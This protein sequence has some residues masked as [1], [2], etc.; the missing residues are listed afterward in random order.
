MPF[1][2]RQRQN[3]SVKSG[4]ANAQRRASIAGA[5]GLIIAAV[6]AVEGGYV[7][8]PADPGGAT[9]HGVTEEVA[10]QNG[11]TGDMRDFPRE[12]SVEGEVCAESIYRRDYI[13]RPGYLP[14]VE[15]DPVV[16]EEVIDTAVNM[17]P[18]RPSRW[19]QQSVNA[20]C[21]TRLAVDGRIGPM[22]LLAWRECRGRI[23]PPA[24][25]DML[26]RMDALQEAE[27][28]RLVRVN[29]RLARFRRGWQNHRIGNVA[30]ERCA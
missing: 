5:V 18:R 3:T 4:Q 17:G 9:N 22:T 12:C 26:D 30:R 19:F 11:Y 2:P 8:D 27:Y 6:F 15:I 24:C 25:V 16:A 23:G 28:D 10:R 21:N 14:L 20:T 29:P 1:L 13:E 7:N